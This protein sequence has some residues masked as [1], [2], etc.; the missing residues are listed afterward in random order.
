MSKSTSGLRKKKRKE[1]RKDTSTKRN[2]QTKKSTRPILKTQLPNT[3]LQLTLTTGCW[4]TRHLLTSN[5][6]LVSIKLL[7]TKLK[8]STTGK[9]LL[10]KTSTTWSYQT[11]TN[12]S[13]VLG[14]CSLCTS[15]VT[16]TQEKRVDMPHQEVISLLAQAMKLLETWESNTPLLL[17]LRWLWLPSKWKT[18]TKA[19][20]LTRSDNGTLRTLTLRWARTTE[21]QPML[22]AQAPAF[23]ALSWRSASRHCSKRLSVRSRLI[24]SLPILYSRQWRK[25]MTVPL[26]ASGTLLGSLMCLAT[27]CCSHQ[28]LRSSNGFR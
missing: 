10:W 5:S 14:G 20:A 4:E 19:Y 25:A 1:I 22:P 15:M 2:G 27:T 28:S 21:V 7:Q 12:I 8:N 18:Q 23:A 24:Q 13:T 16:F 3:M 26:S 6:S 17:A 9:M 11:L